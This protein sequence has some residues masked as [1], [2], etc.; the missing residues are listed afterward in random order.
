M[1]PQIKAPEWRCGPEVDAWMRR[2]LMPFFSSTS[3][4]SGSAPAALDFAV[5]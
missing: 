1:F 2:A 3:P 4:V 5:R